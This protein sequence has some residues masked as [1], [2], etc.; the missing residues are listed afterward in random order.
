MRWC[1]QSACTGRRKRVTALLFAP[2]AVLASQ[3]SDLHTSSLR[4]A[5]LEE[6]L[7]RQSARIN[8]LERV[9]PKEFEVL[10]YS[11]LADQAGK[12]MQPWLCYGADVTADERRELHRR[13]Y[14]D[15]DTNKRLPNKGWPTWALPGSSSPKPMAV[16]SSAC[17]TLSPS[18]KP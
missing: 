5:A 9:V 11:V 3:S 14:A 12:N 10:H 15:G 13:F 7:H 1:L 16:P 18:L 2:L 6:A 8:D 17:W 4:I